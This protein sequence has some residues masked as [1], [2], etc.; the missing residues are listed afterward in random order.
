MAEA[1]TLKGELMLSCNC[2]VF[3]PCVVS[4]GQHPPTEGF[5][6]GWMGVRIDTGKYG[7]TKLSGLNAGILVD[8]PGRMG[9]GN[10]TAA[11][12]ID[13]RADDAQAEALETILTGQAGGTTGLLRLLVGEYLGAQRVPITYETDGKTR[14]F[15]AG[16]K[17]SG[18]IT[19]IAAQPEDKDV[20]ITNSQ[21]W[22]G[23][24][25]IVAA[26]D[27]SRV[28]DFGRVWDFPGRSAE[29]VKLNWSGDGK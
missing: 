2:A 25:I 13:D 17:L 26:S 20:V 8:I 10:W 3:C 27:K 12:Y 19:P 15:A 4:L 1:W 22:M 16:R 21:Y 6:M 29:L 28:R 11:L 18:S 14:R 24:D 5:C 23:K 7:K 9:R